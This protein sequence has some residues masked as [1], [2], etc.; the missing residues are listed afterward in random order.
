MKI[1]VGKVVG[2][3]MAKTATVAVE[4]VV[5]H[6]LYKKRFKRF[7]KFQVHDELGVKLGDRVKFADSKPYSKTIKWI[8][9]EVVKEKGKAK[10]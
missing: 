2:T 1:F 4:R 8:I 5:I 7:T 10:K 3:K 6:P 9:T